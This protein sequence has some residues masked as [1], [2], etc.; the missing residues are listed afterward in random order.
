MQ[1]H[2]ISHGAGSHQS[3]QNVPIGTLAAVTQ[4]TSLDLSRCKLN[5]TDLPTFATSLHQLHTLKL[6]HPLPRP[7]DLASLQSAPSLRVLDCDLQ[8][9]APALHTGP[10]TPA[11]VSKLG[12]LTQLTSLQLHTRTVDM[13]QRGIGYIVQAAV[14][15]LQPLSQLVSL[16]S[17]AL[18]LQ[19]E[20]AKAP[21]QMQVVS[22]QLQQVMVQ[23]A[24]F[25]HALI[26]YCTLVTCY[27]NMTP[28]V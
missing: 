13:Q 18:P 24:C 27:S 28:V 19:A 21:G 26:T 16:Q 5:T 3:S 25:L 8:L 17:L 12:T 22:A 4:V 7:E 15:D 20:C 14:S 6:R 2:S 1:G 11:H 10:L 9:P 23:E